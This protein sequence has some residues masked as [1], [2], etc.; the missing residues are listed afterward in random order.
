MGTDRTLKRLPPWFRTSLSTNGRFA[1]VN[2]RVRQNQLHTVC[3]SAACPNR[4]E[5]WNAGTATFLVLGD[6]CT[7]SCRFC[8]I[9]SGD[10]SPVDRDEP[11]RVADA[12]A[13]LGLGYAV[14]TSVTRDDLSDGG[15][16]HFAETIRAI[17]R[18]APDCGVE[19]LIPDFQGSGEALTTVLETMPDVLNHNIETVPSLY[20][21]IRPQADYHRS[22]ELLQRTTACGIVSK[23]GMM[24][25]LGEETDEVRDVL[26]SLHEIGCSLLTLGQYLQPSRDHFPV[27]K[28]YRPEEFDCIRDQ[29]LRMGFRQ[30]VA[31]P[32][33]RSSYHAGR[34]FRN[35]SNGRRDVVSRSR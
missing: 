15:A 11:Q 32:L 8:N 26:A 23:T 4:N 9:P 25:G 18:T 31:G 21:V 20:P 28:Y 10:P 12:V 6:R 16:G 33:V 3:E 13:A 27:A 2:N 22:L 17:R 29:A 35:R 24:L 19:V 7:R 30:V 5:C 1:A 34:E 14:V